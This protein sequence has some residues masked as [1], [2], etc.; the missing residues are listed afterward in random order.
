M[1]LHYRL[2]ERLGEG[3]LVLQLSDVR[4]VLRQDHQLGAASD[5]V[6]DQARA[7]VEVLGDVL[8]AAELGYGG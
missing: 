2:V 6:G 3:Q 4:E 5:G 1:L 8:S 7:G